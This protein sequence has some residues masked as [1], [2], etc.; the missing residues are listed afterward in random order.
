M[1][2]KSEWRCPICHDGEEDVAYLSPCLHQFCVGCAMR[3][4]QQMPNC[5][6]CQCVATDI[7]FSVWSDDDYLTFAV[8]HPADLQD[9]EG[10]AASRPQVDAFPAEVW[11]DIFKSHP[12]NIE[13]LMP[14]LRRELGVLFEDRWWDVAVAESTI[15]A[16]LC[17][18]G[19]DKAV[20][21]RQLQ[22][23]LPELTGTF[24]RHLTMLGVRLCSQEL[25]RHL[26]RQDAQAAGEEEDNKGPVTSRSP[27]ASWGDTPG[28]QPASPS[29]PVGSQP[30]EEPGEAAATGSS[31]QGNRRSPSAPVRARNR[32]PEGPR[33]PPKRRVPGPQDCPQACKRPPRR[34]H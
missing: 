30:Q 28:P 33:R 4:A 21:E 29:S 10:A 24:F 22:N 17:R 6:V 16:H 2:T 26:A 14:W 34:R 13:P 32:S 9:E 27:T 1:A 15:V 3:W 25:R 23:C 18:W 31:S 5:A 11:A 20:L 19:L 8:P 7:V 12:K